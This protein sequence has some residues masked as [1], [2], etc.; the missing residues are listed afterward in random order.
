MEIY[1]RTHLKFHANL[2]IVLQTWEDCELTSVA[3]WNVT[4]ENSFTS[5]KVLVDVRLTTVSINNNK[6][7]VPSNLLSMTE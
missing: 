6:H 4:F 2:P 7:Q 5:S 3:E 1:V